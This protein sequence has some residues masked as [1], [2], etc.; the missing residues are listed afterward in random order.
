MVSKISSVLVRLHCYNNFSSLYRSIHTICQ[1]LDQ[2]RTTNAESWKE[3]ST[4]YALGSL[5]DPN[6]LLCNDGNR[7][8]LY[9]LRISVSCHFDSSLYTQDLFGISI[10]DLSIYCM[11]DLSNYL[12]ITALS[13]SCILLSYIPF[14]MWMG[15]TRQ[16]YLKIHL[17]VLWSSIWFR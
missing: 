5:S 2:R 12:H 10:Y 15:R 1:F 3:L 16:H 13:T 6:D 14:D 7:L 17:R 8:D 9:I 4:K 11:L